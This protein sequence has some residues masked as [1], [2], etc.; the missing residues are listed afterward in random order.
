[1]PSLFPGH[2]PFQH[3]VLSLFQYLPG[4][5]SFHLEGCNTSTSEEK[6]IQ[7]TEPSTIYWKLIFFMENKIQTSMILI[8]F[9]VKKTDGKKKK[10]E[11]FTILWYL[12]S[13]LH[14]SRMYDK[15]LSEYAKYPFSICEKVVLFYW[16]ISHASLLEDDQDIRLQ[17]EEKKEKKTIYNSSQ[18]WKTEK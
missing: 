10:N 18:S 12:W 6:K 9:P 2:C 13:W 4:I 14:K 11:Y 1:M 7:K 5:Y 3:L 15:Y 8:S 16:K 17:N